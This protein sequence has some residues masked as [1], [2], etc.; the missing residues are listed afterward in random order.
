MVIINRPVYI[1]GYRFIDVTN[2]TTT[3]PIYTYQEAFELTY[4]YKNSYSSYGWNRS[5]GKNNENS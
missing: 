1:N 4:K 3:E 2:Q 5:N